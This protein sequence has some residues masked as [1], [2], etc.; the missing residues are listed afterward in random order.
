[1]SASQTKTA[2][3]KTNGAK[4]VV[5][6]EATKAVRHADEQKAWEKYE[7]TPMPAGVKSTRTPEQ[8][9][10][11]DEMRAKRVASEALYG[12][13]ELK[14][15]GESINAMFSA[16]PSGKRW[17]ATML[18]TFGVSAGVGYGVN[19]LVNYGIAVIATYSTAAAWPILI[20]VLGAIIAVYASFKIGQHLGGYILSGQIDRDVASAWNWMF[21]SSKKEVTT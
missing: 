17:M 2:S 3:A 15:V 10:A 16:L 9:A 5:E 20:A 8:Q 11:L 7:A 14:G 18:A 4:I 13:D 12:E 19:Q 1:M 21:G 6:S